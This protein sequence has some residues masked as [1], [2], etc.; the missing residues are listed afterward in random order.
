MAIGVATALGC[1]LYAPG[2]FTLKGAASVPAYP[3]TIFGTVSLLGAIGDARVL[4]SGAPKGAARLRRHLWRM[5][6]ALFVASLAVFAPAARLP[7]ALRSPALRIIG[8]LIP[9]VAIA[10]WMWRL[11]ARRATQVVSGFV[12]SEAA[13]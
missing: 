13:S 12:M 10:F 4:R 1:A 5:C 3:L 7:I 6:F 2:Y 11:R 9:I 8:V